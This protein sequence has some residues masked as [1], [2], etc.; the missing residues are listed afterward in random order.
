[1][2][3][4]GR[5]PVRRGAVTVEAAIV[6]PVFL[7]LVLGVIDL[8]IGVLRQETLSHAAR[9]A[10][11]HAVVHGQLCP[12]GWNGGPWG[13]ATIDQPM[14]ASGTPAVD[15]V[16]PALVTCPE[17]DTRVRV[18]WPAGSNRP[19]SP[20]RVTVTSV[21]T[22]IVTWIFGNP[23]ITLTASSTMPVCH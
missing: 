20:V 7:M 10:A 4:A 11:R 2:R 23:T 15:L 6:V 5:T 9:E 16:K 3:A 18:E 1:M 19:G 8:S 17:A 13:T 22:P 21:Y 14:T 12:A